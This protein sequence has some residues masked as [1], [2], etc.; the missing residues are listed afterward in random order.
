[1]MYT[2]FRAFIVLVLGVCCSRAELNE[3]VFTGSISEYNEPLNDCLN[4]YLPDSWFFYLSDDAAI[5]DF[6]HGR[7]NDLKP[8]SQKLFLLTL[9]YTNGTNLFGLFSSLNLSVNDILFDS[10]ANDAV[11]DFVNNVLEDDNDEVCHELLRTNHRTAVTNVNSQADT[12]TI[13]ILP[14][15]IFPTETLHFHTNDHQFYSLMEV[16]KKKINKF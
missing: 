3:T 13:S 6:F 1:M 4:T 9:P 12:I 14:S 15:V 2:L 16:M 8:E 5:E 11:T 10:D 7:F